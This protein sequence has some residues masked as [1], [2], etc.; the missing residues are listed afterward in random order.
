MRQNGYARLALLVWLMTPLEV[1]AAARAQGERCAA[2]LL[3]SAPAELSSELR[4]ALAAGELGRRSGEPCRSAHVELRPVRNGLTVT[5]SA[6]GETI[7]R[8]VGSVADAAF[9]VESWLAP[10]LEDA[11]PMAPVGEPPLDPGPVPSAPDRG[12]LP[13]ASS[14]GPRAA[15]GLAGRTSLDTDGVNWNGMELFGEVDV[16]APFWLG[17]GLGRSWDYVFAPSALGAS[18]ERITTHAIVRVGAGWPVAAQTDWS[19]GVGAGVMSAFVRGTPVAGGR[20]ANDDEGVGVLELSSGLRFRPT[21]ALALGLGLELLR[22]VALEGS[23][24]REPGE[25]LARVEPTWRAGFVLGVGLVL[26]KR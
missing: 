26:G 8:R 24:A 25:P 22:S 17:A 21:R 2:A 12:V 19:I 9:W 7:S 11:P 10:S 15:L 5:L 18:I 4:A 3:V 16:A 23:D 1:A 6:A 14:S 20:V 13:A